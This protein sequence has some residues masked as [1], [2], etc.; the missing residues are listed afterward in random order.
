[1]AFATLVSENAFDPEA[2]AGVTAEFPTAIDP[3]GKYLEKLGI[4]S[5]PQVV[6]ADHNGVVRYVGH[7]SAVTEERF[8]NLMA[9]YAE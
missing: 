6:I 3:S 2:D 9:R 8:K 4:T 7:P 5:L 1:V